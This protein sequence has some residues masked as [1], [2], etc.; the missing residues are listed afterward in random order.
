MAPINARRFFPCFDEPDFKA[1]LA[2]SVVAE[3]QLEVLSNMDAASV[4]DFN[5]F[6]SHDKRRERMQKVIFNK[7]PLMSMYLLRVVIGKMNVIESSLE[8]FHIPIRV[9]AALDQEIQAA[10]GSL[11]IAVSAMCLYEEKFELPYPLPKLD[12]VAVPGGVGG[13]ENWGCITFEPILYELLTMLMRHGCLICNSDAGRGRE[14]SGEVN[15]SFRFGARVS[16]SVVWRYRYHV[17][18]LEFSA[19][20]MSLIAI[21]ITGKYLVE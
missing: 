10:R 8:D 6:G 21:G 18:R 2:V 17:S 19:S 5:C 3:W 12:L 15:G 9:W 20:K 14:C 1:T 13:M 11:E 4:A 16:L 7:T